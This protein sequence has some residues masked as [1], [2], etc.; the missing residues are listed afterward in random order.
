MMPLDLTLSNEPPGHDLQ[1]KV[2]AYESNFKKTTTPYFQISKA[3]AMMLQLTVAHATSNRHSFDVFFCLPE[4]LAVVK[5][6]VERRGTYGTL[7]KEAIDAI[8]AHWHSLSQKSEDP[9]LKGLIAAK[10]NWETL[11]WCM[12]FP[13]HWKAFGYSLSQQV[14]GANVLCSCNRGRI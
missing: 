8:V 4:R 14:A 12:S 10:A 5:E 9:A 7:L 2:K 13:I 3:G 11:E 6:L 1:L